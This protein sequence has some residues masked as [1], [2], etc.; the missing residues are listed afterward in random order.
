MPLELVVVIEP[1]SFPLTAALIVL[2]PFPE[3]SP[4]RTLDFPEVSCPVVVTILE[5]I[6]EPALKDG[7]V[8]RIAS[9]VVMGCDASSGSNPMNSMSEGVII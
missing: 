1:P 8:C 9:P 6:M 7:W 4:S 3:S 5:P 2:T